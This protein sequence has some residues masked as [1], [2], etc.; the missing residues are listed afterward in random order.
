MLTKNGQDGLGIL[1]GHRPLVTGHWSLVTDHSNFSIQ[2]YE[3]L[4]PNAI[5]AHKIPYNPLFL[6]ENNLEYA[7]TNGYRNKTK[8]TYLP[9][10]GTAAGM[11]ITEGDSPYPVGAHRMCPVSR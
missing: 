11:P 3:I 5:G 8:R 2:I 9:R 1:T 6:I 4:K 7:N 10:S